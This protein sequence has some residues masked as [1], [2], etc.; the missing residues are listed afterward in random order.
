MTPRQARRILREMTRA[1]RRNTFAGIYKYTVDGLNWFSIDA[2][3]IPTL[4]NSHFI[5]T[6]TGPI[7]LAD[8]L[9]ARDLLAAA[10]VPNADRQILSHA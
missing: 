2:N 9:R 3:G 7:T 8:V 1:D 5:H 10:S 6:S 4:L